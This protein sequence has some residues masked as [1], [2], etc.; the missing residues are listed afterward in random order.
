MTSQP[1][2]CRIRTELLLLSSRF[3]TVF[4]IIWTLLTLY[5]SLLS[6]K[7]MSS[8]N[9]WKITGLDKLGHAAFYMFFSLL[10][11]MAIARK[12]DRRLWI[13]MI[14]IFFGILMETGQYLMMNGRSF[15]VLDIVANSVGAMLG[16]LVFSWVNREEGV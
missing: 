1:Q 12:K 11:S 14:A 9:L 7:S 13:L 10:W 15:E 2:T 16:M 6:A 5:L 8:L 3:Y 4:A